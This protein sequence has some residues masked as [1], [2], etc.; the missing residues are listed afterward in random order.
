MARATL[1]NAA[2]RPV[3]D[4]RAM[5]SSLIASLYECPERGTEGP[6][7]LSASGPQ[8]WFVAERSVEGAWTRLPGV[9]ESLDKSWTRVEGDLAPEVLYVGACE[10]LWPGVDPWS[11]PSA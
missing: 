5:N 9:P 4:N 3:N 10:A 8:G 7:L 6:L 11:R 1:R 2:L